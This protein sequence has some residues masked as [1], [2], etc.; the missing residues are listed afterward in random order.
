MTCA[1]DLQLQSLAEQVCSEQGIGVKKGV[2]LA[3]S[4]PSYETPAEVRFYHSIGADLVGMSTIPEVI[5]ARHCGIKVFGMSVVTNMSNFLNVE[6]NLNDGDDVV[7]Q[8]DAASVK[9]SS[10][11]ATMIE[12]LS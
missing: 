8:A 9:M 3:T 4:G 7:K 2:Y 6:K 5:V 1:Y 12:R 10:L 11:F